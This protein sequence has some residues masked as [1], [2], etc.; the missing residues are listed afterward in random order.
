MVDDEEEKHFCGCIKAM[1]SCRE[2]APIFVQL[3]Q[4]LEASKNQINHNWATF[5]SSLSV[6]S[7]VVRNAVQD[8]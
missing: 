8:R 2:K 6:S 4:L 1:D 3:P 5:E 7:N